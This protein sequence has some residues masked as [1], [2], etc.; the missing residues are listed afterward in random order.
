MIGVIGYIAFVAL[1]GLAVAFLSRRNR[2]IPT[3]ELERSGNVMGLFKTEMDARC[4]NDKRL[5]I[6]ARNVSKE[7]YDEFITLLIE[8]GGVTA[9]ELAELHPVMQEYAMLAMKD[10]PKLTVY[11]CNA[12]FLTS[13][14]ANYG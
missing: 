10:N 5:K 2:D 3:K 4:S 12:M 13:I 7:E 6:P 9:N 14:A 8:E 1:L 11:T